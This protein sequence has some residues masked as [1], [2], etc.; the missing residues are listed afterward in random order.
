MFRKPDRY[1]HH[2]LRTQAGAATPCDLIITLAEAIWYG[3]QAVDRIRAMTATELPLTHARPLPIHF[4]T[5]RLVTVLLMCDMMLMLVKCRI[6][7]SIWTASEAADLSGVNPLLQ[8]AWRNRGFL[9]ERRHS[10]GL[11]SIEVAQLRTLRTIRDRGVDLEQ[12]APIA[13][14]ARDVLWFAVSH[15]PQRL[16][17]PVGTFDQQR[18]FRNALEANIS[19]VLGDLGFLKGAVGI[20]DRGIVRFV[21]ALEAAQVP[22]ADLSLVFDGEDEEAAFILDLLVIG[23]RLAERAAGPLFLADKIIVDASQSKNDVMQL[24]FEQEG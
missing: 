7:E 16:I 1:Q 14:S 4:V 6:R 18:A 19:G 24:D 17:Q 2:C 11:T 15:D 22:V 8:R 13:G 5:I 9:G 10:R 12:A 23:R 20:H 21:A 3:Y